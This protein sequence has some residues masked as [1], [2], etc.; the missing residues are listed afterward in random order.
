MSSLAVVVTT[1]N[2]VEKFV[3]EYLENAIF[4]QESV[5]FIVVADKKTPVPAL[6]SLEKRTS[7]VTVLTCEVQQAFLEKHYPSLLPH[8]GWNTIARSNV[9]RLW[10]YDK[11]FSGILMLDDD[12]W[13]TAE[14]FAHWHSKV[15][16]QE[17][18]VTVKSDT[19]WFNVAQALVEKDGVEFY[20]RGFPPAQRWKPVQETQALAINTIAVNAGLWLGD[21]D[22]DAITRLERP[23]RTVEYRADW[24]E[25]FALYPGTWSPWNSQN[26]AISREA[27]V[28]YW[29]SPWAGRH[30]DIWAS[31]ISN[32][33]IQHM[34]QVVAFGRPL[35][36]HDRVIH[37]LYHDLDEEKPWIETTDEFVEILR[38]LKVSGKTYVETM[39]SIV[40][41]LKETPWPAENAW[42]FE[43]LEAWV[44]IFENK[45]G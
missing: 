25:T 11:G 16:D 19:G 27:L 21:P 17:N 29:M 23:L 2:D 28:S 26:S 32:L 18:L 36:N 31:Y 37:N 13:P 6:K 40:N 22:I 41:G 10:A 7:M 35:V 44:E 5:Q 3:I 30:L 42:Y 14:N 34:G 38:G 20:P 8:I 12:N 9:G 39:R 4:H 24:P 33:A 1:I 45:K 15:G 43:G